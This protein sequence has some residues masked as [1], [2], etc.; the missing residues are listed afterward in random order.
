MVVDLAEHVNAAFL[1]QRCIRRGLGLHALDGG[2]R[3]LL[4][5]LSGLL[6]LLRLRLLVRLHHLQQ[7][8]LVA[9]AGCRDQHLARYQ[10]RLDGAN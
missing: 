3:M 5:Y 9:E 1:G 7:L 2:L 8:V 6:L 10:P 4:R